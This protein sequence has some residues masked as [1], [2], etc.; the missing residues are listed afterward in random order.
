MKSCQDIFSSLAVHF[1]T[2]I[3][4]KYRIHRAVREGNSAELQRAL[5][6]YD[7]YRWI[8]TPYPEEGH[9][10]PLHIA[11]ERQDLCIAR[12]LLRN[13]ADV[14]Q[15]L[16]IQAYDGD[17]EDMRTVDDLYAPI[18]FA[19]EFS[20]NGDCELLRLLIRHGAD[21]NHRLL[22]GTTPLHIAIQAND[23]KLIKM[24]KYLLNNGARVN[25]K[26]GTGLTTP[27]EDSHRCTFSDFTEILFNL[28]QFCGKEAT[29][30]SPLFSCACNR[31]KYCSQE[32][33][34]ADKFHV[35]F[36][37]HLATIKPRFEIG[38]KVKCMM[39]QDRRP[40][41]IMV[42]GVVV[43]HWYKQENFTSP[44]YVPY[45]IR[46]TGCGTL[47]YSPT[48]TNKDVL[49]DD[50]KQHMLRDLPQFRQFIKLYEQKM[51]PK[52]RIGIN[53]R[54]Y[55]SPKQDKIST[56]DSE[57]ENATMVG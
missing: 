23:K 43:R 16:P 14:H 17:P 1:C 50:G 47:I 8:N 30:K 5:K 10:S 26:H 49:L 24:V 20:T 9:L 39:V 19:V 56:Y 15:K 55:I 32:C 4:M 51:K 2:R 52:R 42:N 54:K 21:V 7:A 53:H 33:Q 27:L 44:E 35:K 40:T 18:H 29:M 46:I 34:S 25:S 12:M 22:D 11:C 31:N 48:D 37:T 41:E 6:D 13:G 36:C 38:Q 57:K 3:S 28:C 45:Q